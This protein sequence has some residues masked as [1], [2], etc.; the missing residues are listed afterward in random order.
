MSEVREAE[1]TSQRPSQSTYRRESEM[2]RT[3]SAGIERGTATR[4]SLPVNYK[5]FHYEDTVRRGSSQSQGSSD[6]Q[7]DK[8]T[9]KP[10]GIKVTENSKDEFKITITISRENSNE[11]KDDCKSTSEAESIPGRHTVI[12]EERMRKRTET[13]QTQTS[14]NVT[15]A[16][17]PE[18]EEKSEQ[19]TIPCIRTAAPVMTAIPS[20]QP[21]I[22][23]KQPTILSASAS[24]TGSTPFSSPPS[25]L[26]G[27][28]QIRGMSSF[29]SRDVL[30]DMPR[31]SYLTSTYL[32]NHVTPSNPV[33]SAPIQ[34]RFSR[35]KKPEGFKSILSKW[36]DRCTLSR[37]SSVEV[38]NQRQRSN[39]SSSSRSGVGSGNER[40]LPPLNSGSIFNRTGN[41]TGSN[42]GNYNFRNSNLNSRFSSD[43][44]LNTTRPYESRFDQVGEMGRYSYR[45]GP[46]GWKPK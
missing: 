21:T 17:T 40:K 42:T 28:P 3:D 33:Q 46:I 6:K 14:P 31:R 13:Q 43:N 38:L 2:S 34:S 39:S 4:G 44:T 19:A 12:R 35:N 26:S 5:P 20:S 7:S 16:G 27:K 37:A 15:R 29:K 45:Q 41:Q 22:A 30:P 9:I 18:V 10:D 36:E 24:S 8:L 25:S 23:V 32:S 11:T 1:K